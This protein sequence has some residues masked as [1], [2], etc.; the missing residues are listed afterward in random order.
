MLSPVKIGHHIRQLREARG[1]SQDYMAEALNICQSSYA[2]IE[3]GKVHLRVDRLYEIAAILEVP[4]LRLLD[5]DHETSHLPSHGAQIITPPA[6][7]QLIHE[8]KSEIAFLRQIV[9]LQ[10]RRK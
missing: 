10:E 5:G 2:T 1:Y 4:P 6:H 8:L 9:A 3:S 7:D